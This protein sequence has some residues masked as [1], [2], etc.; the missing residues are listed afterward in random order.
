MN[1][2]THQGVVHEAQTGAQ[3]SL[4]FAVMSQLRPAYTQDGFVQGVFEQQPEG[5]RL[6]YLEVAGVV[7]ATAGFRVTRCLAWGK[8]LYVDDLITDAA[9]RSK[10]YG[11]QL[12]NWLRDE[13]LRLGCSQLHLDSGVQRKDAHRFY[14][15]MNMELNSYH[16]AQRL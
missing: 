13:A 8:F 15:R 7:V 12:L 1:I 16:F 5:Y 10:G 4:C 2:N 11:K 14:L 6:A 9:Q 3:I